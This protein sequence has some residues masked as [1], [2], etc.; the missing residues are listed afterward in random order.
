MPRL[1]APFIINKGKREL[2]Q[3]GKTPIIRTKI[4]TR[5]HSPLT[6]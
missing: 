2:E 5:P 4:E 1:Q 6:P 3:Q